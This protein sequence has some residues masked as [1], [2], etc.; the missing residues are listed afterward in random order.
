M[1]N[2]NLEILGLTD[3]SVE[4]TIVV[5]G[6]HKGTAY[7]IGHFIGEAMTVIGTTAGIIA[8]LIVIPKS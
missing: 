6:G 2:L 3:L 5:E 1:K 4:E 8:L 7:K